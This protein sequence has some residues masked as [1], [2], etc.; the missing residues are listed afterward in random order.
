MKYKLTEQKNKNT[1][2]EEI[3]SRRG[4]SDP[5]SYMNSSNK[6]I[7]NYSIL[8]ESISLA[9]NQITKSIKEGDGVGLLVDS[10]P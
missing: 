7:I 2:Q 8:G 4:V 10:D 9:Y 3:L 5:F 1:I 6:D